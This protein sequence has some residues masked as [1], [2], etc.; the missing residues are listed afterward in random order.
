MLPEFPRFDDLR[1][2]PDLFGHPLR[3]TETALADELAAAASVLMG[4][5]DE[6]HPVVLISGLPPG[7]DIVPGARA[8]SG[9][10]RRTC[11][12][13]GERT[14]CWR[15]AGGIGGAKLAL[16]LARV[17]PPGALT[18]AVNTGDDFEH[19]GLCIS[20]DLDTVTYALAGHRQS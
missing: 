2:Q 13:D 3:V 10:R 18:I 7:D 8:R 9:R 19:L 4:Q 6:G 5:A 1:G 15:F 12:D 11:S 20:P 14:T 17:L 16:G